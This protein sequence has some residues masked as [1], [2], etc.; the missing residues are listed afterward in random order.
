[1]FFTS[2]PGYY[3]NLSNQ[4]NYIETTF[5]RFNLKSKLDNKLSQEF[6]KLI[7]KI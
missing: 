6:K 7:Y 2:Y 1:M 3:L 4:S 5:T